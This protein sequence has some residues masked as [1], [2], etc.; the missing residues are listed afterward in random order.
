M[1]K[2]KE[3]EL[4]AAKAPA[5]ENGIKSPEKTAVRRARRI[6]KS[7]WPAQNSHNR[8]VLK[9]FWKPFLFLFSLSIRRD[10][11]RYQGPLF[12]HI[13]SLFVHVVCLHDERCRR[14]SSNNQTQTYN[15]VKAQSASSDVPTR[16]DKIS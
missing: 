15:S 8:F 7:H 5:H 13:I 10:D 9:Y 6:D 11:E 14:S 1:K 12:S 2:K 3:R 16:L 4:A